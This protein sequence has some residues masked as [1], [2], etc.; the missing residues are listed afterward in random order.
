MMARAVPSFRISGPAA[1]SMLVNGL[2][3]AALL[4]LGM[5][6]AA[7]RQ[8]SPALTVLSLAQL[9]GVEE[10]AEET[11]PAAAS[12]PRPAGPRPEVR[13]PLFAA[14]V[15]PFGMDQSP[16]PVLVPIGS[17]APVA[18]PTIAPS[19]TSSAESAA[20]VLTP[21]SPPRRG[22]ADG[23]AIKAPSGTSRSYA[24]KVRSWLYAHKV[25]P[26]RARMRRE[27][28]QVQ[29]RFVLDRAGILLE[30]A[31]IRGSGN[32]VLDEEARAM[33][34]RASPYPR[35]PA[36]LPGE[37]IEFSAPIEFILPA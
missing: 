13:P 20:T 28:G 18:T 14:M 24:A 1:A 34:Q 3:I 16:A 27:E 35:A 9:K 25:Y 5:G 21:S 23:A 4:N 17:V 10:G 30:G 31:V 6:Q 32:P 15:Q 19:Q 33:L 8:E 7:R 12:P 29:V 37:R 26:R 36:E 11:E 2:L 22:A